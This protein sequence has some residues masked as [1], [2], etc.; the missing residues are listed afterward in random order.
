MIN[1]DVLNTAIKAILAEIDNPVEF[2]P[3]FREVF[4]D[5]ISSKVAAIDAHELVLSRIRPERAVPNVVS[6]SRIGKVEGNHPHCLGRELTAKEV[7]WVKA[8]LPKYVKYGCCTNEQI[9]LSTS[10]WQG[11]RGWLV[12]IEGYEPPKIELPTKVVWEGPH[13]YRVYE[14]KSPGQLI[15]EGRVLQHCIAQRDMPYVKQV[16]TPGYEFFAIC[17]QGHNVKLTAYVVQGKIKEIKGAT[18]RLPGTNCKEKYRQPEI[19]AVRAWVAFR[20]ESIQ[21]IADLTHLC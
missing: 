11:Y 9:V 16:G 21:A 1:A 12:P 19:E 3:P 7:E 18:N 10:K 15:H 5:E 2:G 20:G 17:D 4:L 14:L 8:H 6:D 13:G